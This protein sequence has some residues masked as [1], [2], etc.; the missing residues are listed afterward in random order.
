MKKKTQEELRKLSPFLHRLREHGDG[1]EVPDG[2]FEQMQAEVLRRIREEDAKTGAAVH[3]PLR[4]V[5]RRLGWM[6]AAAAAAVLLIA[7]WWLFRPASGPAEGYV[8]T[9]V[10][11]R[12]S[13]AA[14]YLEAHAEEFDLALLAELAA[15]DAP[16]GETQA[17]PAD[18]LDEYLEELELEELEEL[19]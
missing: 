3:P 1:M 6:A 17:P 10:E 5:H 16:D 8:A 12:E 9:A 4:T 19:L 2:Y 13:D 18:E 7:G 11:I 14:A 15:L